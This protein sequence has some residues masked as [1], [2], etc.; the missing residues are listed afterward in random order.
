MLALALALLLSAP[1]VEGP[2]LCP[3]PEAVAGLLPPGT[4]GE[5]HRVRLESDADGTPRVRLLDGSGIELASLLLTGTTNCD[6]LAGAAAAAVSAWE[7]QLSASQLTLESVAEPAPSQ[8]TNRSAVRLAASLAALGTRDGS[9]IAPVGLAEV[10]LLSDV[11]RLGGALRVNVDGN[12]H[13]NLDGGSFSYQRWAIS[14]GPRYAVPLWRLELR[15]AIDLGLEV[16][17]ASGAGYHSD[18]SQSA[19]LPQLSQSLRL[20]LPV[21]R[22]AA[23]VEGGVSE[24]LV[25]TRVNVANATGTSQLPQ[26]LGCV[27]LGVSVRLL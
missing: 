18:Q 23:F 17:S 1:S 13:A 9:S 20:G 21:G 12:Q 27:G 7:Q 2:S 19:L 22:F 6:A 4:S 24:D 15:A 10:A 11:W 5:Q 26:V 14:A 16:L 25:A 3:T 8:A